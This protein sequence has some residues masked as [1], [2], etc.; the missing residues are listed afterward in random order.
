MVTVAGATKEAPL[1]GFV[2]ETLGGVLAGG[3]V[4]R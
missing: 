1:M 3:G 4:E 2:M